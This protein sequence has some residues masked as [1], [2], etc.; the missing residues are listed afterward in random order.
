MDWVDTYYLSLTVLLTP[1]GTPFNFEPSTP[2]SEIKSTKSTKSTMPSFV[3]DSCQETLKK[4]KLD[5]HAQRCRQAVFSCIDCHTNFKGT[6]Y[7]AHFSCITEVQKYHQKQQPAE[8]KKPEIKN[9]E[10][11]KS[12]EPKK[13]ETTKPE[14]K[15]QSPVESELSVAIKKLCTDSSPVSFKVVK[16]QLKK[17][18]GKKSKKTLQ[19]TLKFSLQNGQLVIKLE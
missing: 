14:S 2:Q 3:C 6:E 10:I 9:S 5:Q 19:E 1:V 7:R 12:P 16:K 13:S 17:S 8:V 11:K 18:L 15:K 4:A